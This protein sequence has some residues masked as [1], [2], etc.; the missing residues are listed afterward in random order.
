MSLKHLY[1]AEHCVRHP[2]LKNQTEKQACALS[3]FHQGRKADLV[4]NPKLVPL[5]LVLQRCYKCR[6]I[7][8]HRR[9]HVRPSL[10]IQEG[11]PEEQSNWTWR[12]SREDTR[13]GEEYIKTLRRKRTPRNHKSKNMSR[14][15][16]RLDIWQSWRKSQQLRT[17]PTHLLLTSHQ[18][19]ARTGPLP[20]SHLII[21]VKTSLA[22]IYA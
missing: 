1:G 8:G 15:M 14:G 21:L 5:W 13:H 19:W 3:S 2:R 22:L 11:I 18:W 12:T 4:A 9:D 7:W 16:K 20:W 6:V 17:N 10:W